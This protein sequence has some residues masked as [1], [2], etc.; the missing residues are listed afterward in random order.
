M[1]DVSRGI[2]GVV[3]QDVYMSFRSLFVYDADAAARKLHDPISNKIFQHSGY[4]FPGT[5]NIPCNLFMGNMDH[6]SL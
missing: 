2:P 6:I 3:R 4:D 5:S 1:R